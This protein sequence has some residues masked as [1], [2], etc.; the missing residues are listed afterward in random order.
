M[1]SDMVVPV[2]LSPGVAM[3]LYVKRGA[4]LLVTQGKVTIRG[5]VWLSEQMVEQRI[6]VGDGELHVVE[7]EGWVV[8]DARYGAELRDVTSTQKLDF[9]PELF[10]WFKALFG[11]A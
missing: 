4:R 6:T 5:W 1:C 9:R 10:R 2:R 11:T 8:L 7:D 3:P